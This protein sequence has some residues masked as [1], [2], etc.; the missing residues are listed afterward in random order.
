MFRR[1]KGYDR[2]ATLA[3]ARKAVAKGR[4]GRAIAAY[5][6]ILEHEPDDFEVRAKLAPLQAKSKLHDAAWSNF[7]AAAKGYERDGFL[8][9]A[10]SVYRQAAHSLPDRPGLWE[11]LAD[12]HLQRHHPADALAA[13]Q[14]GASHFRSRSK[15]HTAIRLLEKAH[16]IDPRSYD[17]SLE[18]AHRL[19]QAGRRTEAVA[20]LDHVAD[21]EDGRRLRRVRFRL[22]RL[23]PTPV[24]A[25]HWL[26]AAVAAVGAE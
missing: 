13:L 9:K 15:R 11:T 3:A 1:S 2:A 22:L 5:S 19:A 10:L 7:N 6:R 14:E 23:Q 26:R 17:V 8:E 21:R 16:R 12:L 20:L 18:L 4:V 24:R 25:W